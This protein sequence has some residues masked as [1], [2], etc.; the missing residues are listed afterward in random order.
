M[1]T[2]KRLQPKIKNDYLINKPVF[3]Q[4]PRSKIGVQETHFKEN[5]AQGMAIMAKS[6][7]D[8]SKGAPF[9]PRGPTLLLLTVVL[10]RVL[11]FL[12]T[13]PLLGGGMPPMTRQ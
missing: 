5:D 2:L 8:P 1:N 3:V 10:L 9:D 7:W 11:R 13:I 4:S 12:P 6:L